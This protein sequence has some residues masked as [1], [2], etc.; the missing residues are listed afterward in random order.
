[1]MRM[2]AWQRTSGSY[3]AAILFLTSAHPHC[4]C[5]LALVYPSEIEGKTAKDRI[6]AGGDEW[7]EKKT[8]AER[9]LVLGINGTGTWEKGGDWR[10]YMRG[11]SGKINIKRK[12]DS[13]V[14]SKGALND[15]NDPDYKRRQKHSELYYAEIRANGK[16]HF[17]DKVSK[18]TGYSSRFIGEV[19]D[20]VFIQKHFLNDGYR[21]FAPD[22]YMARSFQN[23]MY[24]KP[25]HADIILLRHEHL[26]RALEKRYNLNYETAHNLTNTKYDYSKALKN[27]GIL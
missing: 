7:L 11:W 6:K 17:I 8:H 22:F 5:H 15:K 16:Q 27:E 23:L 13:G 1:M 10:R 2:T 3:R 14:I 4:L 12:L 21:Y 24:G 25:N 18:N 9:Y 20:Y 26:E 19:Y